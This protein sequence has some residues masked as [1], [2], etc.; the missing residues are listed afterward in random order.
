MTRHK[1]AKLPTSLLLLIMLVVVVGLG[2][3]LFKNYKLEKARVLAQTISK[4]DVTP[5]LFNTSANSTSQ[6]DSSLNA[7]TP[8]RMIYWEVWQTQNNQL[9]KSSHQ[10]PPTN[11]LDSFLL[12]LPQDRHAKIFLNIPATDVIQSMWLSI[13]LALLLI[14]LVITSIVLVLQSFRSLQSLNS[15]KLDFLHNITHELK[16]PVAGIIATTELMRDFGNHF[17]N[18]KQKELSCRILTEANRLDVLIENIIDLSTLD[19]HKVALNKELI[20]LPKLID[21][22]SQ[23]FKTTMEIN[24]ASIQFGQ[25][26]WETVAINGSKVLIENVISVVLDN[27]LKYGG[28]GVKI[29]F[30]YKSTDKWLL[31]NVIDDGPGIPSED[32]DT[33]FQQFFRGRS[34]ENKEIKGSGLGLHYAKKIMQLHSGDLEFIPLPK[35]ACFQLKFPMATYAK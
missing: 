24:Q 23:R 7:R 1:S 20:H 18:E 29:D 12:I 30:T 15:M 27:A 19:Q 17:T 10:K 22:V 8:K 5:S 9:L 26:G 34:A 14:G 4:L 31:L 25:P 3:W 16:T 32:R 21:S 13:G 28:K 35:G 2:F 11:N 33:L 6:I